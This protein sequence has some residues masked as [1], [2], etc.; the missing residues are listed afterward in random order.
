MGKVKVTLKPAQYLS[1]SDLQKAKELSDALRSSE[2]VDEVVRYQKQLNGLIRR[3][4]INKDVIERASQLKKM[5]RAQLE[6]KYLNK[7]MEM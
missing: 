6:A 1:P 7:T 3:A 5:S 4:A 2:K